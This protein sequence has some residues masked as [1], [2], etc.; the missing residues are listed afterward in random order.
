MSGEGYSPADDDDF[1]EEMLPGILAAAEEDAGPEVVTLAVDQERLDEAYA[2]WRDLVDMSAD[3]L[4]E[5]SKSPCSRKASLDPS[6][7]IERN[8]RLLRKSKDQWDARDAR[9]ALRTV[10][11][12]SRMLGMPKGKP[13]TQDCPY[14]KRDISLRNW[15]RKGGTSRQTS[16]VLPAAPTILADR[17]RSTLGPAVSAQLY[18]D[19]VVD[20]GI[21]K[22][23]SALRETLA[24]VAAAIESSN[25][26]E[27]VEARLYE[28]AP[29]AVKRSDDFATLLEGAI[30]VGVGAG[31]W[32]VGEEAD[33]S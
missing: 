1:F 9:D 17:G 15:A 16:N 32:A 4:E 5:W 13:V 29:D 31:A 23:P 8:L 27:E 30:M 12:I 6:A 11:F 10:S 24:A 33:A 7:V 25:G 20:A 2:K 21:Q 28:L 14:S 18:L 3:E 22:A 26:Y 19:K